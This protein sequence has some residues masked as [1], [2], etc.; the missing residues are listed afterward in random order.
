MRSLK[1]PIM[2]SRLPK[3]LTV[4]LLASFAGLTAGHSAELPDPDGKP[5]D[6]SKKVKVFIIMGQSNTLEMGKVAGGEGSLENA[7]KEENL[8][9]FLIDDEANWT[10]RNDVRQVHV[11]Q[12]R[13]NMSVG[14]NDFLS[15]RGNKI[16]IDQGI[17]HE[18]GNAI[19]EPVMIL[20]SSIGNRSLGWDLLPPGSERYEFK[21]PKDEKTYAYPAYNDEV[22]HSRW[23]KGSPPEPPKHGWYA[24]KQ[25]DDDVANAKKVLAEL[26]KYYPDAKGYEVA[27]FL[28]WQGDKDRYDAGHAYR[29]GQN[30]VTLVKAL[31]KDF[32]APNAKFVCA[33]LG[34]TD[35]DNATGNEK[36]ILEGMMALADNPE[37][38]GD[39]AVVYS[40][41][42]SM[43]SASNAH[44]SGNAKTYMNVGLS[45]G[46][47]MV[48]LLK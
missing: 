40:H 15:V 20:R 35:K 3:L 10:A 8:Y 13:G 19:D 2:S 22:R 44:Y 32:N 12:R 7:V 11:M 41:P 17:G 25:Y 33:T 21:D 27:G 23:E 9:P 16:G 39:V 42:L 26:D 30:L 43:G 34:Q 1:I 4:A 48:D 28:W 31:R 29:Y 47:A 24:G 45:M 18:L 37:F 6:M 14:R 5:A 36:M 38:K 46:Q